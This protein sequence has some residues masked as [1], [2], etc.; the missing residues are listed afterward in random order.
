MPSAVPCPVGRVRPGD[1]ACLSFANDAEQH[2][3]AASFVR[4]GL[5]S[6][7]KVY[8]LIDADPVAVPEWL[9]TDTAAVRRAV[10]K[11]QLVVLGAEDAYLAGESFAPDAMIPRFDRFINAALAEGYAGFRVT[12]EMTW[13]L[14]RGLDGEAVASY[15]KQAAAVFSSRAACALCQYDRRQFPAD[16]LAT[17]EAA[18]PHI[19]T[20]DPLYE[21]TIVTLTPVYD[22]AGL[23][24]TGDIDLTNTTGWQSAVAAVADHGEEVHLD[25]SGLRFIDLQGVR[26]LTRTAAAMAD[27]R[28]LVLDSAPQGLMMILRLTGWDRISNLVIG[29]R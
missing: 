25:L 2:D 3:V 24:V 5:A 4:D 26:V 7:Q 6:R 22:P 23:R 8:Y 27:G 1:H 19:A 15:E 14:R 9:K 12:A 18:H 20:A 29:Q 11:G 10:D 17:A 13:I 28:R 16:M 21:D